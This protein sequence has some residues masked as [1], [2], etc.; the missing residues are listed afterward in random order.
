V[1]GFPSNPIY[2]FLTNLRPQLVNGR[3]AFAFVK[4]DNEDAPARA[5]FEEVC[6]F[7]PNG[8]ASS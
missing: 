4:F 5:V 3:S 6:A 2:S 8:G 1:V 7:I